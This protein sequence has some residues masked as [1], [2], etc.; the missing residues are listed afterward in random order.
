[1][2]WLRSATPIQLRT[3]F[4]AQLG[5]MLDGMDVMLYAFALTTIQQEFGTTSAIAGL[6]ASA[7][8][9]TAAIGQSAGG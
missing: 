5:W 7:P 6:L 1:M 8:L 3:L 4:A 2:N 9:F